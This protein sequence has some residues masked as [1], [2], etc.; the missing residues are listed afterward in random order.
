MGLRLASVAA[1]LPEAHNATFLTFSLPSKT[2][3]WA[4]NAGH[5]RNQG[6]RS[7]SLTALVVG[8]KRTVCLK[9][10]PIET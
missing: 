1:D 3:G 6:R 5:F 7:H 10:N 8:A 2:L 4:Y 9:E